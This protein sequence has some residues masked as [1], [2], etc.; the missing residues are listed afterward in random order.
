MRD[1]AIITFLTLDGV[2]QAPVMPDEDFS[3]GFEHGG[4]SADYL[5]GVMVQVNNEAMSEPLDLVFGRKT[6][7][8]FARHWPHVEED[9]A[10]AQFLNNATKYVATSTLTDLEWQNSQAISGD[11]ASEITRLKQ[12]NG[13]KLQVHGSWQ[14]IQTL[15]EHGL[16]DEL[17]LWTFPVVVGGGKKL[18]GQNQMSSNFELIKNS[19]TD[20]GVVMGFYRRKQAE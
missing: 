6:Y 8:L 1:L 14:L 4:W 7:E 13:P 2:M 15:L 11:I 16:V 9:N 10:H 12:Q 18:F 19:T 20:G 3:G 17:R 5:E